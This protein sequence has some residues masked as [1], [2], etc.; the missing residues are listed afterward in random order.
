MVV[1]PDALQAT[2]LYVV[3]VPLAVVAAVV[4]PL[5]VVPALV[6]PLELVTAVVPPV[7]VVHPLEVAVSLEV[8]CP[9]EV[10]VVSL[11][12]AVPLE[13]VCPLEVVVLPL[14]VVVHLEVVAALEVLAPV[15]DVAPPRRLPRPWEARL[16]LAFLANASRLEPHLSK[17]STC[18]GH[19]LLCRD[20]THIDECDIGLLAG[21]RRCLSSEFRMSQWYPCWCCVYAPISIPIRTNFH[22]LDF[23]RR[24]SGARLSTWPATAVGSPSWQVAQTT[25][26]LW[27]H[28]LNKLPL[29]HQPQVT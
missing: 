5:E 28:L 25:P 18:P 2:R 17:S 15:E 12:V 9:L 16:A 27:A 4:A 13:V 22:L 29:R 24:L 23:L 3:V 14:E 8:V 1:V 6:V 20:Q 21:E 19:I 26:Q 10:V 7:E 11:E